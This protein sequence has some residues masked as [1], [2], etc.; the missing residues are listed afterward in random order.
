VDF[1]TREVVLAMHDAQIARYGGLAGVRDGGLLESAL[2]RPRNQHHYAGGDA[3]DL[4]ASLAFGIAR[5]HPFLDANKRTA[6]SACMAFL[7]LNGAPIP[8]PT[9]E[10]V[11]QMVRLAEGA[12]TEEDFAAW[13]RQAAG[14]A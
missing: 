6:W 9:P 2:D 11:Q 13:L 3:F 5:N 1:L 14:A 10:V 7:R 4:A 8:S 12:V